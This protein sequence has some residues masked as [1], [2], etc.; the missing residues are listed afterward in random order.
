LESSTLVLTDRARAVMFAIAAE[1]PVL[2]ALAV[3]FAGWVVR[4]VR[5]GYAVRKT[6]HGQVCCLMIMVNILPTTDNLTG[7]STALM[8][9]GSSEGDGRYD[10]WQPTNN[11]PSSWYVSAQ[12]TKKVGVHAS[13]L[14]Y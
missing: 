11:G 7:R 5:K 12:Q 9:L 10:G 2:V 4:G 1:H 3:L 8:A 13:I 6:F 14:A